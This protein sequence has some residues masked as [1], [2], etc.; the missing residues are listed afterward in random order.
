MRVFKYEI[1]LAD[2]PLVRLPIGARILSVGQ[3][4]DRLLLWAMVDPVEMRTRRHIFRVAGTGHEIADVSELK[5][6]SSIQI[7]DGCTVLHIFEREEIF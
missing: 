7:E 1:P 6:L 3:Q 4:N 2:E 5:F